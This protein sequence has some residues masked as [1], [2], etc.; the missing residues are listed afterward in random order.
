MQAKRTVAISGV[1]A[2]LVA[3]TLIVSSVYIPAIA[4]GPSQ[5]GTLSVML[6][7]PPTVPTGV[8]ALYI[9]YSD[10]Q[11]HISNAGNE[12]G[13]TTLSGSGQLNLMSLVNVSQTIATANIKSGTFNAIRFNITSASVTYNGQNYTADLVYKENILT[14]PIMGGIQVGAASTSAALID[15]TPTVFLLGTPQNPSFALMPAARG[16]VVPSQSIPAESHHIGERHYLGQDSWW[17]AV[18]SETQFGVTSISLT[19]NSFSI[20]VENQGNTSVVYHLAA[21]TSGTSVSGGW[22]SRL[23]TS[24]VFVVEPNETLSV[25]SGSTSTQM[26][27]EIAAGGYLLAPGQSA[28]FTYSGQIVIG[29][30]ILDLGG[31]QIQTQ[32]V[33]PGQNYVASLAGNGMVAQASIGATTAN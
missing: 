13:W 8:T 22:Q 29:Q 18:S 32:L 20:T 9:N 21:I 4:I 26:Y 33:I 5:N 11:V 25:L 1:I 19:P 27:Q 31:G 24:D 10:V 14:V 6:T 30:Q 12:S 28:T 16:Y 3:I 17:T 23:S 2:A 7:D 15:L